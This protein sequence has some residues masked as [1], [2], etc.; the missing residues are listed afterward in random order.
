MLSGDPN[1]A[2]HGEKHILGVSNSI[3]VLKTDN[4]DLKVFMCFHVIFMC[5]CLLN[6][7]DRGVC[8]R[9]WGGVYD[10]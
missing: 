6:K 7:I 10:L 5:P 2:M 3:K 9:R 1:I 8:L 4:P